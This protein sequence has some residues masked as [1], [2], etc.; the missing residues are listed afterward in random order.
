MATAIA[1]ADPIAAYLRRV[2]EVQRATALTQEESEAIVV[3]GLD[4]ERI[5]A[6]MNMRRRGLLTLEQAIAAAKRS[7]LL[8]RRH[9]L[10]LVKLPPPAPRGYAGSLLENFRSVKRRK[11]APV[12]RQRNG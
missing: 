12:R 4:D 6:V 5:S 3:A 7:R 11:R 2:E 9:L 10:R 8:A 1:V